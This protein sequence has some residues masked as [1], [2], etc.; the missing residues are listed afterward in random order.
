MN[1]MGYLIQALIG[2]VTLIVTLKIGNMLA[3]ALKVGKGSWVGSTSAKGLL[4]Q[5]IM[6]VVL[7]LVM[8]QV[9]RVVNN[10]TAPKA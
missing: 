10:F 9:S 5:G 3:P 2:G 7:T 4:F 6:G 8:T 1:Y